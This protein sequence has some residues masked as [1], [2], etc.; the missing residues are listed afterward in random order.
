[1]RSVALIVNPNASAVTPALVDRVAAELE[2]GGPVELLR[3]SGPGHAGELARAA[4]AD[5]IV[6]FGGDGTYNEVLNGLV[7]DVPLGL[8]PGG[9]TSVLPRALGL[10]RDPVV[11]AARIAA[12]TTTRRISLGRANGRRFAFSCGVGM[13]AELVRRVDA[14]GRAN[15]RRPGDAVFLLELAK[16]LGS[17]GFHLR[18]RL[19]VEGMGEAALAVIA[20]GDPYTYVGRLA[21]RPSPQASFE[22]GLDLVA[23]HDVGPLGIGRVAWWTI[24]RPGPLTRRADVVHAHDADRIVI[25]AE[26]P[27]AIQ[28]DG[29]DLGDVHRLEVVAERGAVSILV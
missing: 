19:R 22:G 28:V 4:S 7:R 20:N 13:D 29:E 23:P 9:G 8:V 16:L 3:T 1:M 6:A 5:A 17:Q 21:V 24:V 2:R 15:G 27:V 26:Q 14:H 11:C 18:P 25:T 10:P 12:S